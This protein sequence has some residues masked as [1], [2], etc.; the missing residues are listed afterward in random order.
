MRDY[1]PL[2]QSK[3]VLFCSVLACSSQGPKSV[4]KGL[5]VPAGGGPG[6]SHSAQ[7]DSTGM[8]GLAVMGERPVFKGKQRQ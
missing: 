7:W 2:C 3:H 4:H 5:S 6:G 1:C 8:E